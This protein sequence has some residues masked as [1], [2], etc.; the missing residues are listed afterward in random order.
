[1]L[2]VGPVEI[3]VLMV[4]TPVHGSA[5]SQELELGALEA[6]ELG[7][8]EIGVLAGEGAEGELAAY[9]LAKGFGLHTGHMHRRGW[10]DRTAET[11]PR[12]RVHRMG[13]CRTCLL[14]V[15]AQTDPGH[16]AG[17][18]SG[19]HRGCGSRFHTTS[20]E[21]PPEPHQG[22]HHPSPLVPVR[23]HRFLG[24]PLLC[25]Q[26]EV[27]QTHLAQ[28]VLAFHQA[29]HGYPLKVLQEEVRHTP[30]TQPPCHPLSVLPAWEATLKTVCP[31]RPRPSARMPKPRQQDFCL[32]PGL[33]A[34]YESLAPR[35]STP[36]TS[37]NHQ[38]SRRS[39]ACR[40]HCTAFQ[41]GLKPA[42]SSPMTATA[43]QSQGAFET[44]KPGQPLQTC[45][46][47]LPQ[48][49]TPQESPSDV[50]ACPRNPGPALSMSSA[51]GS[52]LQMWRRIPACLDPNLGRK[53]R[54]APVVAHSPA[55]C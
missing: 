42:E 34:R 53:G 25:L 40:S 35:D 13:H 8:V 44:H 50:E 38:R 55:C 26:A 3:P 28:A 18:R 41:L 31:S 17:K 30:S 4:L 20:H 36:P 45:S 23:H 43:R 32:G 7:D 47:C 54:R 21:V 14:G 2:E 22:C 6:L 12:C 10:I 16:I 39:A 11:R 52:T 27:S 29:S 48:A 46:A 49:A 1:M 19:V 51:S 37:V 15:C 9:M 33:E 5:T 24:V